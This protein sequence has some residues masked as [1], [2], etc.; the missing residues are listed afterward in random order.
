M[1]K[2]IDD[3]VL[4]AL[5]VVAPVDEVAGRVMTRFGDVIDRFS[6]YVPYSLDDVDREEIVVGLRK[7]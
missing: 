6:L 1:A 7:L 5:S 3:D 4:D 2:L